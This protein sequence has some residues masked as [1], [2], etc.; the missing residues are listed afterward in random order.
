MRAH[1]LKI[2]MGVLGLAKPHYMRTSGSSSRL[3]KCWQHVTSL[4]VSITGGMSLRIV[5]SAAAL[6]QA[7]AG[8]APSLS[9]L[10]LQFSNQP[11]SNPARDAGG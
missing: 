2:L 8:F 9:E 4:S 5:Q 10:C 11:G 3:V 7:A 1:D 6:G